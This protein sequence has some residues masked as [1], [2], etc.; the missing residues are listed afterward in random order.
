MNVG[1]IGTGAIANLH[2]RVYKRIGFTIVVCTDVMADAAQRFAADHGC[3]IAAT[4][5]EVCRHPAIDYVDVCT[6]P[7]FRL[8]A[9]EA[10]AAY[11]R[12]VQVQKPMAIDLDT[13][14]RMIETAAR[15]NIL[16]GV[17]SQHRFDESSR[18]LKAALDAGRLGV[19]L[20]FD[21]YVKWLGMHGY[22]KPKA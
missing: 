16:L 8:E 15:S 22:L 6:L 20:Q 19:P 13:A 5:A 11:G 10:A 7:N 12:H 21:A 17:V 3:E 2:A 18:F 1:L 4:S 9:V 14:R